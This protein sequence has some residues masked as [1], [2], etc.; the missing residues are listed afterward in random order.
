[1][2]KMPEIGLGLKAFGAVSGAASAYEKSKATKA[3]YGYQAGVTENNAKLARI[4]AG[5]A[6]EDGQIAE[7]EVLHKGAQTKGSQRAG[8]AAG[9]V[10]LNYG[11][12]LAVLTGTDLITAAR[13]NAVQDT[14]ARK[15]WAYGEEAKGL[16]ADA[17]MLRNRAD[18]ESPGKAFA[19]SLLTGGAKP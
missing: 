10:A 18:A 2:E 13:R 15:V 8:M 11:S 3:A 14:T 7:Q 9:G 16:N 5:S 6:V 17:A 12:A 19:G 4:K 1:M